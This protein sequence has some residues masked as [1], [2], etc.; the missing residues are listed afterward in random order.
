MG[1][2]TKAKIKRTT[3]SDRVQMPKEFSVKKASNGYTV[4]SWNDGNSKTYVAKDKAELNKILDKF[5]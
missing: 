3:V 4:S 5:L 2:S 1:K